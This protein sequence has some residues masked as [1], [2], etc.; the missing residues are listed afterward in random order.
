MKK[1]I[2]AFSLLLAAIWLSCEKKISCT[3]FKTGTFLIAN[4]SSFVNAQKVIRTENYQ[5]QI[6]P[7]GDTLFAKVKWLNDCSYILT[8]DKGKMHLNTF[9]INVNSMGGILVEYG[10]PSGTIMPYVAVLKG[11]TKTETF[12]GYIKRI[13]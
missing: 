2:L 4:D 8:F 13:D 6:S 10:Q 1:S 5:Q 12:P 11:D 3:D 7:K 9:Q